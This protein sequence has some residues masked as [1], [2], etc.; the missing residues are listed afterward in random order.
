MS[1]HISRH[2]VAVA[3]CGGAVWL[4]AASACGERSPLAPEG[5]PSR[6]SSAVVELRIE[7]NLHLSG[8]NETSQL[9]AIGV[10]ATG[11]TQDVTHLAV[12]QI[13]SPAIVIGPG[14]SRC[15]G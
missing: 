1:R 3:A 9:R 7:G 6:S 11:V 8:P 4:A 12:W 10:T 5:E 13:T 14:L 2:S 15:A